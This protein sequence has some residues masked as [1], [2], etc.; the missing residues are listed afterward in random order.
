LAR[1]DGHPFEPVTEIAPAAFAAGACRG[2]PHLPGIARFP[3]WN[4]L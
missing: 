2:F 3:F 1:I 4:N